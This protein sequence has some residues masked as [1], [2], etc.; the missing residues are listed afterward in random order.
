MQLCVTKIRT[1]PDSKLLVTQTPYFSITE[2]F[3]GITS[4]RMRRVG[5]VIR[6]KDGRGAYRVSVG[7]PDRKT[8]LV[9]HR[10]RLEDNIK[11]YIPEAGW[12]DMD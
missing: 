2:I 5:H 8:P 1:K 10:R 9:R 12:G 6:M 3:R 4:R 7:R 11:M